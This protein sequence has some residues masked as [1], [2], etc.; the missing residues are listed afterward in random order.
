MVVQKH[1]QPKEEKKR[2]WSV[3]L[4]AETCSIQ[5]LTYFLCTH[6]CHMSYKRSHAILSL[7]P[8]I[9]LSKRILFLFI[10]FVESDNLN[11]IFCVCLLN[12]LELAL[13]VSHIV[14]IKFALVW[15]TTRVQNKLKW[16]E[17]YFKVLGTK[18]CD[19]RK[20]KC[21]LKLRFVQ[22]FRSLLEYYIRYRV[23]KAPLKTH[24]TNRLIDS[25]HVHKLIVCMNVIL[26]ICAAVSVL[27]KPS[28]VKSALY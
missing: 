21:K 28:G 19:E 11:P 6:L 25:L 27:F 12:S 9:A 16:C 18:K 13:P 1:L 22:L 3:E 15:S 5:G 24:A 10:I 14:Q 2:V 20:Q 8:R 23:I 7:W 17:R 4:S 26:K